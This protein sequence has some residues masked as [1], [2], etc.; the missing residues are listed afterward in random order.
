MR[1]KSL[2]LVLAA[3]FWIWVFWLSKFSPSESELLLRY[4]GWSKYSAANLPGNFLKELPFP[5]PTA[6]LSF[7]SWVIPTDVFIFRLPN[8]VLG[9][10]WITAM[11]IISPASFGVLAATSFGVLWTIMNDFPEGLTL[12]LSALILVTDIKHN[13]EK[14]KVIWLAFLNLWLVMT[15]FSGWIFGMVFMGFKLLTGDK[16]TFWVLLAVVGY[17]YLAAARGYFGLIGFESPITI[18]SDLG[19]QVDQRVRLETTINNYQEPVPL[20][21]KR[22]VYNKPYFAFRKIQSGLGRLFSFEKF[23]YPGQGDA[24][25]T[26][27]LWGSKGLAWIYYWQIGISFAA[28]FYWRKTDRITKRLVIIYFVWG[29]LSASVGNI[30]D[31]LTNSMGLFISV[32]LL[33]AIFIDNSTIKVKILILFLLIT[34]LIP[35]VFHLIYHEEVWRDN[36]PKVYLT[37]AKMATKHQADQVSTLLGRPFLYYG[38]INKIPPDKFWQGV[39]VGMKIN[40][41]KFDHFEK[42]INKGVYVGLPGEFVGS[43]SKDGKNNFEVSELPEGWQVLDIEKITDTVSYGNGDYVWTVEVN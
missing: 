30:T 24:T 36:R 1:K 27:S 16:K 38:W 25:V 13:N 6:M 18:K 43:K 34:S 31:W 22:L 14:K 29:V 7:F 8:L 11:L 5:L 2:F 40:K 19:S 20:V 26:R 9:L 37:M 23:A 21:I 39:E 12:L 10:G 17:G 42:P 32:L 15:S 28:L 4:A 41:V 3:L 35:S 33:N